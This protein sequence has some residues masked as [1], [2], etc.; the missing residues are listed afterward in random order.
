MRLHPVFNKLSFYGL[1]EIL[2]MQMGTRLIKLRENQLL[3]RQGDKND[4]IYI[5]IFGKLV[6]H[7]RTLGAIGVV[8]M[9]QTIGEESLIEISPKLLGKLHNPSPSTSKI[10]KKDAVY[11]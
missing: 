2:L 4:S 6:L 7:H 1:R 11:A 3:Y 8:G 10:L 5:V 9:G